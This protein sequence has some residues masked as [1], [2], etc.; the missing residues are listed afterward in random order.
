MKPFKLNTLLS[1]IAF[2]FISLNTSCPRTIYCPGFPNRSDANNCSY[3]PNDSGSITFINEVLDST[4]TLYIHKDRSFEYMADCN[5]SCYCNGYNIQHLANYEKGL[6][7]DLK[8]EVIADAESRD[9]G[10]SD[11]NYE[12]YYTSGGL[13]YYPEG[14]RFNGVTVYSIRENYLLNDSINLK[15]TFTLIPGYYNSGIQDPFVDSSLIQY[16]QGLVAFWVG[17]TLWMRDDI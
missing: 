14:I 7:F 12:M 15:Q 2:A 9:G 8:I 3:M 16:Q 11:P 6:E 4:I 1:L 10:I 5:R 13:D 17:D